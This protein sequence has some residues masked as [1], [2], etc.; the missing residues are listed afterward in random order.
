M[1]IG[2]KEFIIAIVT[3]NKDMVNSSTAPIF[4]AANEEHLE[5]LALLIAKTTRGMVHDLEGGTYII[6]KH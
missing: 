1:E 4:Y 6:V 3:L 5:R 2:L